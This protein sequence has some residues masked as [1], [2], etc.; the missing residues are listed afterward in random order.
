MLYSHKD[1]VVAGR[2]VGFPHLLLEDTLAQLP[3]TEDA[4]KVLRVK[5]AIQGRDAAAHDGLVAAAAQGALPAVE[6]QRAQGA[7]VQLH[8][9]AAAERLQTVLGSEAEREGDMRLGM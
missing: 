9:A 6:V 2:A 5:L 3:L 4:H 1:L 8:E 7:T